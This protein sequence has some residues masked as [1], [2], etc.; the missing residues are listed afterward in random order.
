MELDITR[1][2]GLHDAPKFWVFIWKFANVCNQFMHLLLL[3]PD[4]GLIQQ[5]LCFTTSTIW[6]IFTRRHHTVP[7]R[8]YR[9]HLLHLHSHFTKTTKNSSFNKY[10]YFIQ[11]FHRTY[12]IHKAKQKL[13]NKQM[14]LSVIVF[15]ACDTANEL[16]TRE[17][18]I[19]H[20]YKASVC[21]LAQP[22]AF[23]S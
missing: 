15:S 16:L 4:L 12:E 10:L 17:C 22:L 3:S 18:A 19:A 2:D 11:T 6:C 1:N 23:E 21:H 7:V 9:L 13:E 20:D 5:I 14:H 8:R